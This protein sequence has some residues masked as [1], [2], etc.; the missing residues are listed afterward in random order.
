MREQVCIV[1]NEREPSKARAAE[2]LQARLK[3][4][5]ITTSRIPADQHVLKTLL[6]RTP[7]VL[8]LDYLLGDYTTGLDVFS[9]ILE[10]RLDPKPAVFFL[11]DEPGISVA[12]EAM[13]LGAKDYLELE[14]PQALTRLARAIHEIILQTRAS[15]E[16]VQVKPPSFSELIDNSPATAR[17]IRQARILSEE[18]PPLIVLHGNS[19]TGRRTIAE[20]ILRENEPDEHAYSFL[21][22][23][24]FAGIFG[25]K[26]AGT[27]LDLPSFEPCHGAS[28]VVLNAE[29]DDGSCHS[30]FQ[31][32]AGRLWQ[33]ATAQNSSGMLLVCTSTAEALAVWRKL[34]AAEILTVPSLAERKEDIPFL[35]QKFL[36][37]AHELGDLRL[38]QLP[39]SVLT[40][41]Q[42]LP[43]PG[44]IVQLRAC[45]LHA[46]IAATF[47]QEDSRTLIEEQ[48]TLWE[49]TAAA[50]SNLKLNRFTAA[51]VLEL[52]SSSYRIAAARLGCSPA[53]LKEIMENS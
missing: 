32:N 40:W 21:D 11:T 45:V 3:D 25:R 12:V 24:G 41:L 4:Y 8:I 46:S 49:E 44:E 17:L 50:S 13:R 35:A 47:G 33:G 5:N 15:R 37:D 30:F 39:G 36:R 28:I 22:L 34:P 27:E 18:R 29:C 9:G 19:G 20:C 42:S 7:R 43:W 10:S 23:A 26:T 38:K 52:S 51:R 2:T 6:E 14:N 31:R 53:Q 1:L 48:R 16:T